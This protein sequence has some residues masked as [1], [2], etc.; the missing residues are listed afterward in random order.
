MTHLNKGHKKCGQNQ[1]AAFAAICTC[2]L[3]SLQCS[4]CILP[5]TVEED[6]VGGAVGAALYCVGGFSE[7]VKRFS[8]AQK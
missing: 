7:L 8:H 4:F 5:K 3:R 2:V 1:N 6:G